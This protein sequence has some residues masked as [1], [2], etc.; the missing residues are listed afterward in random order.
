MNTIQMLDEMVNGDINDEMETLAERMIENEVNDRILESVDCQAC[1]AYQ[2]ERV[3]PSCEDHVK[4]V[5][6]NDN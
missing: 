6:T 5:M 4:E 1:D 2:N 3:A